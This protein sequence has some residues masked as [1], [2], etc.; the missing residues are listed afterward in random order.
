[1]E[2]NKKE[3]IELLE[4]Y[5][6]ITIDDIEDTNFEGYHDFGFSI[7]DK[8]TGFGSVKSCKLCIKASE[9]QIK[10]AIPR[11]CFFVHLCSYCYWKTTTLYK[12]LDARNKESYR[13]VYD[14]RNKTELL[15]AIQMRIKRMEDV[16]NEDQEF[17][18]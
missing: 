5:K 2:N 16:L 15:E 1:M 18:S 6:S 9:L 7:M 17:G 3:F 10:L 14:A 11:D 13:A 8:L 12:C 4:K